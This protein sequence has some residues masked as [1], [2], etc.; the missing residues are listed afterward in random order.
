MSSLPSHTHL[1]IG[2][3]AQEDALVATLGV[4]I[5]V[6]VPRYSTGVARC[7][8]Y[9]ERAIHITASLVELNRLPGVFSRLTDSMTIADALACI[10]VLVLSLTNSLNSSLNLSFSKPER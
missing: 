7:R 9:G 1:R 10:L 8:V 5:L 2:I 6:N 4:S 3:V